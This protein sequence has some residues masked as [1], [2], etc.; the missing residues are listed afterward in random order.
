MPSNWIDE[1]A[2]QGV[3][4]VVGGSDL[5]EL[6]VGAPERMEVVEVGWAGGADREAR[7]AVT[8]SRL[9]SRGCRG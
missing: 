3:K 4:V 9:A 6:A 5:V 1:V 7:N 2:R 8:Q